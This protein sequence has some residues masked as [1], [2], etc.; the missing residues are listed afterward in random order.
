MGSIDLARLL[1]QAAGLLLGET[2]YGQMGRRVGEDPATFEFA[3]ASSLWGVLAV[4]TALM[5]VLSWYY[6]QRARW[7]QDSPQTLFVELCEAHAL[8]WSDRQL[9]RA[10]ATAH[11]LPCAARVFVEPER[12]DV[13][14]L[15]RALSSRADEITSLK[16]RLFGGGAP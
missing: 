3:Y 7:R 10:L 6:R 2:R 5:L 4:L 1:P 15:P 8:S 14:R 11:E 9:L 13:A 16:H 12:F